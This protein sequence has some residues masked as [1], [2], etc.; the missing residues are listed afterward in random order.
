MYKQVEN[1]INLDLKNLNKPYDKTIK[2][3]LNISD[4]NVKIAILEYGIK[5]CGKRFPKSKL[6]LADINYMDLISFYDLIV[7]NKLLI[8]W[9]FNNIITDIEIYHLDDDLDILKQDYDYI[10]NMIDCGNAH[11]ISEG[12]TKYLGA[13]LREGKSESPN[14]N[15]LARNRCFVFKKKYLQEIINELGYSCIIS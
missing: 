3:Q 11:S 5:G 15:R 1:L 13:A 6:F 4:S 14:N 9:Y 8:F 2:N 10:K 12:D 7:F